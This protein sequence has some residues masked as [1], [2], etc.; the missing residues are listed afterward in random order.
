MTTRYKAFLPVLAAPVLALVMAFVVTSLVLVVA[1]DPVV[2]VWQTILSR[3]D[4]RNVVNVINSGAVLYLSGIAAAIGFRMK[5]FNIGVDGQYRIAAFVA[6]WVAGEAWLPGLA[7]TALALIAAVLVGSLWAGVAGVLRVTRGVH[8]VISTIMLNFIATFL[9]AFLLRKVAVT[10]GNQ[11]G[12]EPVPEGSRIPGLQLIPGAPD[13]IYGLVL[14]AVAVGIAYG[15]VLNRTRFGFELRATGQSPSAAMA[16]GISVKKMTVVAMLLS[17]GVA[18]LIGMPLLFGEYYNY[19]VTFQPGLG[20]AGIAVA[21][22]GRNHPVG[23]AFGAVLFAYLDEQGNKLQIFANVSPELVLIIQGVIVM[24]VVIAYE[25]VQRYVVRT[26]EKMVGVAV[27][28]GLDAGDTGSP[29][30]HDE[31][32]EARS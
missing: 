17:G 32:R 28:E 15:V 10:E 7:N 9:V 20:F 23:V 19:G 4:A 24:S 1:G 2:L 26:E 25:A 27:G 18:G 22:L 13:D 3:P 12:T 11:I 5:L 30:D 8:E 14:L 29:R 6:A 16:S 21:L 31:T